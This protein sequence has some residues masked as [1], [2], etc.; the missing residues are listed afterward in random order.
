MD[1]L[2]RMINAIGKQ[3]LN[4][5]NGPGHVSS[6]SAPGVNPIQFIFGVFQ[7]DPGKSN[8]SLQVEQ[9]FFSLFSSQ[10]LNGKARA[11]SFLSL[12]WRHI[13]NP[14]PSTNDPFEVPPS[15]T[16]STKGSHNTVGKDEDS[17]EEIDYGALLSREFL[18]LCIVG[19]S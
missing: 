17:Q 9:S 5:K 16:V 4:Q 18:L 8:I 14:S 7:G 12:I 2:L 3:I 13:E 1:S 19:H 6:V 15:D 10:I 11:R